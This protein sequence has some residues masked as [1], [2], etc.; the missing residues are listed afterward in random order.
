MQSDVLYAIHLISKGGLVVYPTDTLYG[1][2]ARAFEKKAVERVYIAKR[3]PRHLPIPIMV[4][5]VDAISNYA[6]MSPLARLIAQSF[7]PGP[8]TLVLPKKDLIPDAI[9][10]HTVA[11]RVPNHQ[12]A[13]K[14]AREFPITATSANIHGHAAPKTVDDARQ[15]LGDCVDFYIDDGTVPG[16]PSTIVEIIG[17][18]ITIFR[19]GA[20]KR[21]DIYECVR[22][23]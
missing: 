22:R 7:L 23:L 19:D 15:Q 12:I 2:G 14:L 13:C 8:L 4:H 11:I 21:D 16:V 18:K 5:C 3:R 6:I 20:V 9:S 1:L 10:L 17:D